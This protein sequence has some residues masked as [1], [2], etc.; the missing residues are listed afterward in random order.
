MR[1]AAVALA[2]G[3]FLAAQLAAAAD[4]GSRARVIE[5]VLR[6][7]RER[8]VFP[9][10]AI[11]MDGAIRDRW[12]NKEYDRLASDEEFAA[13]LTA[14][15]QA[16][17]RDKHLR[18]RA[19]NNPGRTRAAPPRSENYGFARVECLAGNVGYIDLRE[20]AGGRAAAEKA[21]A[22]MAALADT[23]AL[24]IDLR[25]NGGGSPEMIIL[26]CSYLLGGEPVLLNSFIGRDGQ[27]VSESWT[28]KDLPGARYTGK[29]VYVLTSRYTFSA[30][31]EF[32]YDLANLKRA[33]LI[34]EITG[35]GANPVDRFRIN[36]DFEMTIPTARAFNPIT[37]TNWEGVGVKP[38]IEVPAEAALDRAHA[39]ALEKLAQ[40]GKPPR[41]VQG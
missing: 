21:H 18:V 8:Y 14:D 23:D 11:A 33:T 22:A 5:S 2:I 15:L 20:F 39:L 4:A 19:S 38:E 40:R 31:E 36:D 32:A 27:V 10:V 35:G 12:H 9:D 34:G 25:Q 13:K 6:E 1:C 28:L 7:L 16:V 26:L 37:Q 30:A 24:I 17:S 41:H 3:T 29:E